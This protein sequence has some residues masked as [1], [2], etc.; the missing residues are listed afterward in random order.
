MRTFLIS[1]DLAH[2]SRNRHVLAQLIMTLGTRWARPLDQTWYVT[3]EAGLEEIEGKLAGLLDSDDGMLI[4]A[5]DEKA[6]LTNTALRW[7]RQ[8]QAPIEIAADSNV[9]PFPAPTAPP[10]DEPELPFAEAC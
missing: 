5:V 8:R 10:S 9:I 1:Y 2:P 6:L 4:Q 3:S 7:F